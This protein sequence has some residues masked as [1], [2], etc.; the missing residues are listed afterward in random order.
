MLVFE[1][2]VI[3]SCN[4]KNIFL[5][6]LC[7]AIAFVCMRFVGFKNSRI[8]FYHSTVFIFN[9][10]LDCTSYLLLDVVYW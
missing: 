1:L 9:N 2:F 8:M 4:Y 5:A 6:F 10:Y 3:C 7:V